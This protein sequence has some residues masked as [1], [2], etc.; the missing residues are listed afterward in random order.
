MLQQLPY[1]RRNNQPL[2]RL[3][4]Q[5]VLFKNL[6]YIRLGNIAVHNA[7][8]LH[9]HARPHAARAETTGQR[10][11]HLGKALAL[12]PFLHEPVRHFRAAL[13]PA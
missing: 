1:V 4:V 9:H 8:R 7:F 6:A 11:G 10:H 2:D 3:A 5:Q 13:L 12:L